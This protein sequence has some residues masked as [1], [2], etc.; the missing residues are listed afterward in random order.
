MSPNGS[1]SSSSS[2]YNNNNGGIGIGSGI[3]NDPKL[4]ESSKD[5]NNAYAL[6]L[7]PSSG[8][9][10]PQRFRTG[11]SLSLVGS[12]S[13]TLALANRHNGGVEVALNPL[14]PRSR[15]QRRYLSHGNVN[16]SNNNRVSPNVEP[17][18][19]SPSIHEVFFFRQKSYFKIEC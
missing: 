5:V 15:S 6:A 8:V 11:S 19:S 18:M 2:H 7:V 4:F 13:E 16:K 17:P 3:V 1:Q 12:S 14:N 10:I 9:A